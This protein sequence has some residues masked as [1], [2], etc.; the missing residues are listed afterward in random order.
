MDE[1]TIQKEPW[2]LDKK[3]P[4]AFIFAL[5]LQTGSF[6]W[7]ASAQN[8]KVENL[9]R[10]TTALEAVATATTSNVE[11]LKTE[12][13][14]MV[15]RLHDTNNNLE[16]SIEANER[17]NEILQRYIETQNERRN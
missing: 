4:I 17:T 3:I 8:T 11:A 6:I 16:R 12:V 15:S 2:H 7:W 14:V 5:L 10:R 9:D 13:A 1:Q